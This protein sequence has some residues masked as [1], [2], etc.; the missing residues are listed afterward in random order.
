M[1][2]IG[3]DL[4]KEY[5]NNINQLRV[6]HS[7]SL[8]SLSELI[9]TSAQTLWS[10]TQGYHSPLYQVGKKLGQPK[11]WAKKLELVFNCELHHIFPREIC[12]INWNKHLVDSQI[13]SIL[14]GYQDKY[15]RY[16]RS[17]NN[18]RKVW[19]RVG[20]RN[21]LTE[22]QRDIVERYYLHDQTYEGIGSIYGISKE[23]VRQICCKSLRL[24]RQYC[25]KIE[26]IVT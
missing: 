17:L 26:R 21:V 8:K 5:E 19:I 23:R 22:K 25:L 4:T 7:L 9:G 14:H 2:K 6:E 18:A 12:D 20:L 13:A 24:L 3:Y 15:E 16:G 1:R 11:P 10:I